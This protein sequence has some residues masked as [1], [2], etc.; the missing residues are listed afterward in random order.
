MSYHPG[1]GK[2]IISLLTLVN[3]AQ[4]FQL[5]VPFM[6]S[7]WVSIKLNLMN[8]MSALSTRKDIIV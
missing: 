6:V 5:R 8:I 2:V 3:V 7:L 4:L 1:I